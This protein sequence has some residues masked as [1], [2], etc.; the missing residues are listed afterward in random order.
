[1]TLFIPLAGG[2][3]PLAVGLLALSQCGDAAHTIYRINSVSLL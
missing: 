3:L 1:M 2:P